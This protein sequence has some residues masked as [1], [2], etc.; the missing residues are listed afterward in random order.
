M[1]TNV[2]TETLKQLIK[3]SGYKM[4]FIAEALHISRPTLIN[5]LEGRWPFTVDEAATLIY[6][7][8]LTPE[9][10]CSIFFN[11]NVEPEGQLTA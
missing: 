8:R 2:D 4:Q 5:R 10:A 3:N 6:L 1:N 7:L 9:Q 11:F